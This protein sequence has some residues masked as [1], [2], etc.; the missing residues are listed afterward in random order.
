MMNITKENVKETFKIVGTIVLYGVAV[1][2]SCIK[3][4]DV[5][6]MIRYSG[7]VKYSD[8]VNVIMSSDMFDSRKNEAMELLKRNKDSEYYKA[9]IRIVNSDMFDSNKIRAITNLSKEEEA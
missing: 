5:A 2:Q 8:A 3:V 6:D 1:A 4:K 9:V 7:N